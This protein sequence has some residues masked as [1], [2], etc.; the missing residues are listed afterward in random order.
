VGGQNKMCRIK[1]LST[2]GMFV[3]MRENFPNPGD[4]VDYK[5]HFSDGFVFHVEG[6]G[7]VRWV[8]KGDD[9]GMPR[10][11]GVEFS[12]LQEETKDKIWGLVNYL[13][14]RQYIPKLIDQ[15]S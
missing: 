10:G 11:A 3:S 13:K 4:L 14:T 5:I 7:V 15:Q 8:R 9:P 6:Q 12:K 1:N 2:G